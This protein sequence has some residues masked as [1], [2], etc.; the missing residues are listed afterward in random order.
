MALQQETAAEMA[1]YIQTLTS[2]LV[3]LARKLQHE[4]HTVQSQHHAVFCTYFSA[5]VKSIFKKLKCLELELLHSIY[6]GEF[7]SRLELEGQ[8]LENIKLQTIKQIS[9]LDQKLAV[10]HGA[11]REFE[12]LLALY[13]RISRDIK[14]LEADIERMT[15][16]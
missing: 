14:N 7:G 1:D 4:R 13:S 8:Q 9:A 15:V 5:V 10:Y 6:R 12:S 3:L 16:S 11:G 2:L